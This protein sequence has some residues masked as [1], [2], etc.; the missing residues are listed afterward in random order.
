MNGWSVEGTGTF[1][2]PFF[3]ALPDGGVCPGRFAPYCV[4]SGALGGRAAPGR[5]A[6]A[7][8]VRRSGGK[9]G[10]RSRTGAFCG[11]LRNSGEIWGS[12]N[13]T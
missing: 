8:F 6:S 5:F 1:P 9:A 12:H 13:R 11:E 7:D 3:I 4:R 2:V 10:E